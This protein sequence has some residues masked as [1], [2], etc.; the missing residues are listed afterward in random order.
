MQI[1]H[2][3]PGSLDWQDAQAEEKNPSAERLTPEEVDHLRKTS[4]DRLRTRPDEAR[5][6]TEL[7]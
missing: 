6:N 1:R 3:R 4:E 2:I 7:Q 5:A